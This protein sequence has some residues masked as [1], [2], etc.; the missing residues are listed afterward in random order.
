MRTKTK[1]QKTI[2][3]CFDVEKFIDLLQ[4][5]EEEAAAAPSPGVCTTGRYNCR[6]ESVAI[7]EAI[8]LIISDILSSLTYPCYL[9]FNGLE[10]KEYIKKICIKSCWD[11]LEGAAVAFWIIEQIGYRL[12]Y[13]RLD[14]GNYIISC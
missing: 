2:Y 1:K 10:P 7:T 9:T 8:T 6:V 12:F 5:V 13:S 11:E 4:K 3:T 14:N